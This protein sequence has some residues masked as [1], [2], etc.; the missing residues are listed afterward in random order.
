M[1]KFEVAI[2]IHLTV[3]DDEN[4]LPYVITEVD[5]GVLNIHYKNGYSIMNDHAKVFVTAPSLEK[6]TS[7]GS[8]DITRRGTIKNSN[9]IEIRTSGSGD[10]NAEVDAPSI[11]VSGSGSGNV[12]LSGRT[13]DFDCKISGSGDVKCANLKSENAVI[14]VS[15]SSDVHVFASVSLKVNVAGSGDVYYGG[16]P[17][18]PEIHITGSGTVQAVK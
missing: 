1:W 13:K 16:N 2:I 11:S 15:G 12:T 6:I 7:S 10:I 8:A 17:S 5:N 3:Q 14:H 9:Q 4:L 18:S